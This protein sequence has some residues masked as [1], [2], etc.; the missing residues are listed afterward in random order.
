MEKSHHAAKASTQYHSQHGGT[1]KRVS[2][3]V[4]QYQFW[5]RN[6]QHRYEAKLELKRREAQRPVPDLAR[7]SAAS[8]RRNAWWA[9]DAPVACE[10][11]R[12]GRNRVG[13]RYVSQDNVA[14]SSRCNEGIPCAD[15]HQYG[16]F[17]EETSYSEE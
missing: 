13:S 10:A 12:E 6:I 17:R 15:G 14:E 11:W 7:T 4:Q 2:I 8:K 16:L 5:Y 1:K 3:V 9:S